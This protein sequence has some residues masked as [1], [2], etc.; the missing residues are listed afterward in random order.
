MS[1]GIT[2]QEL[3]TSTIN[4]LIIKDTAG[5]AKVV[6]PAAADD[7]ALKSTVDNAVGTL[8]SLLTSAKGNI[9]TA[10]NELF[11][12]VSNGKTSV[13]AAITGKGIPASG[14]DT[15]EVLKQKI[16]EIP[17][18]QKG[19][20]LINFNE[21]T[22]PIKSTDRYIKEIITLP[23]D[24]S[25]FCFIPSESSYI[26]SGYN[27]DSSSYG[28]PTI[29]LMDANNT[30][31]DLYAASSGGTASITGFYI[32]F[33]ESL[34]ATKSGSSTINGLSKSPGPFK[35]V[36]TYRQYWPTTSYPWSYILL[37]GDLRY[38]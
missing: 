18:K 9:V 22:S 23:N 29:S 12:N 26:R 38:E 17:R 32:L 16:E 21:N 5:R 34:V 35:L 11:T 25:Y 24:I 1:K 4:R 37:R 6:A 10:I 13:A 15:F 19:S 36:Y 20:T 31:Y 2:F 30:L 28:I 7:I 27:S 33:S 3:D 14:S 8:S